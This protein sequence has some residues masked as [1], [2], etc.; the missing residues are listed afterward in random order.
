MS[1]ENWLLT[2]GI[3]LGIFAFLLILVLVRDY[4]D[5]F[6]TKCKQKW[7][8]KYELPGTH[9]VCKFCNHRQILEQTV[10]GLGICQA[11]D[12]VFVYQDDPDCKCEKEGE[13]Q[14]TN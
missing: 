9:R 1:L 5:S 7:A 10:I 12:S 14:M 2:I 13:K 4:F 3:G 11:G 6:C 8:W